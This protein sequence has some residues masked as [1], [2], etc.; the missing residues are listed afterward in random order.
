MSILQLQNLLIRANHN[1]KILRERLM[2]YENLDEINADLL[3]AIRLIKT[4]AE[5]YN[6]PDDALKNIELTCIAIL[7]N[8]K[9]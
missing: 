1:N 9:L 3:E 8:P 7:K 2:A 4:E 6:W 5:E